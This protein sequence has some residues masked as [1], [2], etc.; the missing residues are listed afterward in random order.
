[1]DL[2]QSSLKKRKKKYIERERQ[3]ERETDVLCMFV[4]SNEIMSNMQ[5]MTDILKNYNDINAIPKYSILVPVNV[6][7]FNSNIKDNKGILALG[8]YVT[9]KTTKKPQKTQD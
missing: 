4:L 2:Q 8:E 9:K 5:Y 3:R 6:Y 7:F 1:M